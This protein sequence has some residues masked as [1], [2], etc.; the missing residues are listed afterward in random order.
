MNRAALFILP[1]GTN[2]QQFR[3]FLRMTLMG[4]APVFAHKRRDC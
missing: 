3:L 4:M 2:A 1:D